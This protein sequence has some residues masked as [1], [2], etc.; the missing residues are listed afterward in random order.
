MGSYS[1]VKEYRHENS[2]GRKSMGIGGRQ[3]FVG[4]ML[5]ILWKFIEK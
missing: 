2:T 5:T 1:S 4:N 3:D